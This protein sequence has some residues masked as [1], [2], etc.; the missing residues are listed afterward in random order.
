MS[1]T[2]RTRRR[3]A[4]EQQQQGEGEGEEQQPQNIEPSREQI[5][6]EGGGE[7]KQEQVGAKDDRIARDVTV[8][9]Y[10]DI[11]SEDINLLKGL[12]KAIRK[13]CGGRS[14]VRFE[15]LIIDYCE[16]VDSPSSDFKGLGKRLCKLQKDYKLTD[17]VEDMMK[18]KVNLGGGF[19]DEQLLVVMDKDKAKRD[20]LVAM[21]LLWNKINS[22]EDSTQRQPVTVAPSVEESK[23]KE[24]EEKQAGTKIAETDQVAKEVG[25]GFGGNLG[26]TNEDARDGD[27]E[28]EPKNIHEQSQ[29]ESK[30]EQE[31]NY[32]VFDGFVGNL[33]GADEDARD[34][35]SLELDQTI[36]NIKDLPSLDEGFRTDD[37]DEYLQKLKEEQENEAKK[38][39]RM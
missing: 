9:Q 3:A 35:G 7:N 19:L 15:K 17:P 24:E 32:Q 25:D 13:Y 30:D 4:A 14:D 11:L 36:S 22:V 2:R 38:Q 27:E 1:S 39:R 8:Q 12:S 10:H 6:E 23:E 29:E 26:G 28:E 5:K 31:E 33:D 34:K 20:I 16:I 21:R 37:L 18:D